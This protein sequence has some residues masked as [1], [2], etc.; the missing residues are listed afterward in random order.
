MST[1]LARIDIDDL[2]A[3]TVVAGLSRASRSHRTPGRPRVDINGWLAA[4]DVNRRLAVT[5]VN[6]VLERV[7][8][9]LLLAEA[10]VNALL[11]RAA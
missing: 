11:T 2:L 4:T 1:L 6:A 7:D 3:R 8:M 5:D 9:S 10:Y